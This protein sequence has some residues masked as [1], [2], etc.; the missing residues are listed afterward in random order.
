MLIVCLISFLMKWADTGKFPDVGERL[1]MQ[2][3][4]KADKNRC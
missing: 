4:W 2:M 3:P 1:L